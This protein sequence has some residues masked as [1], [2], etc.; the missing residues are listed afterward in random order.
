MPGELRVGIIHKD[1]PVLIPVGGRTSYLG[2]VLAVVVADDR[3]TARAAAELVEVV[4]E[5]LPPIADPVAALADGAPDAVWRLDGQ[6][7]LPLRLPRGDVEAALA[8]SA[9]DGRRGLPDPAGRARLPRA[10]VDPRRARPTTAGC[11]STPAARA[12]GTTATRSRRSSAVDPARVTVELVSNGGAFGGKED[13]SNQAQTALAA[14]LLGRPV[15][16]TLYREESLLIHAKRHPIRDEVHGR[17]RRRRQAH[18]RC[19]SAW[20]A[21]PGPTPAWA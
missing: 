8:D 1:W 7:A 21:T 11:T 16:C 14:W 10:R 15:K 9:H 13:M 5:V 2:D 12:S 4:Y 3:L 20:S 19:G 17:L 18:R 6:R